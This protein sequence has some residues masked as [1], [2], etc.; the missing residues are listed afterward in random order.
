MIIYTIKRDY[1]ANTARVI[2]R[3]IVNEFEIVF[4]YDNSTSSFTT[5]TNN[6]T[7]FSIAN[8]DLVYVP[9]YNSVFVIDSWDLDGTKLTFTCGDI[10]NIYRYPVDV[11]NSEHYSDIKT[12]VR[13]HLHSLE[14]EFAPYI[15]LD[16]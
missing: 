9:D 13:D 2:N 12:T 6:N 11:P 5:T 10:L 16:I 3:M 14:S 8:G 15:S 4:D 7:N 1:T